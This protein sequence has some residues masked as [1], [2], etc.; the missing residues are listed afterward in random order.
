MAFIEMSDL[1]EKSFLAYCERNGW[2]VQRIT[3]QRIKIYINRSRAIVCSS[4]EE[5]FSLLNS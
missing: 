3:A 2:T 5:F 1:Q 4:T